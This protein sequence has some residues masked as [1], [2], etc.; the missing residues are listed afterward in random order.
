M[1]RELNKIFPVLLLVILTACTSTA[2]FSQRA[3]EQ[4]VSIKVESLVLMD[5]ADQPYSN[6]IDKVEKLKLDIEKAYQYAKGLPNNDE[7]VAQWEIITDP[8]RNSIIGF[9]KRWENENTLGRTFIENAMK[10]ISD[11]FDQ[12]IELESGKRK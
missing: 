10:L 9:L 4:N 7:T 8:E 11:H 12:V 3:Y 2:V 1:Q 5:K 6:Y